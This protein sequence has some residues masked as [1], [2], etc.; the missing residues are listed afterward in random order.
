MR[1]SSRSRSN[2][3]AIVQAAPPRRDGGAQA[4]RPI[5]S[6]AGSWSGLAGEAARLLRR[7][8]APDGVARIAGQQLRTAAG[9]PRPH[10][11]PPPPRP[12]RQ[13]QAAAHQHEAHRMHR[14]EAL[15]QHGHRRQRRRRR[16]E[17]GEHARHP[18]RHPPAARHTT[19]AGRARSPSGCGR[20]A[21][22]PA[23]ARPAPPR[24]RCRAGRRAAA[25]AALKPCIQRLAVTTGTRP[26][27][28]L[29]SS[30]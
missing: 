17:S 7:G 23:P 18:G 21:T 19:A 24:R 4:A 25:S 12:G 10:A 20:P 5:A 14:R 30:T 2:S 16:Q 15:P 13:Q 26:A 28:R 11:P 3:S 29:A 27:M 1:F 8:K 22:R 9:E 6:Q